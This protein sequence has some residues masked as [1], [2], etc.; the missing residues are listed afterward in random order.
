MIDLQIAMK[1]V[2]RL[3]QMLVKN[4]KKG[5]KMNHE[6]EDRL[7]KELTVKL[8]AVELAL[9]EH[10]EII[11]GNP[12]YNTLKKKELIYY[13]EELKKEREARKQRI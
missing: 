2:R 8:D 6:K 11:K 10:A 12:H 4:R 7:V 13:C 1:D 5:D 9:I 3:S